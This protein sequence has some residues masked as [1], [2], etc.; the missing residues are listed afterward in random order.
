MVHIVTDPVA[1]SL[2]ESVFSDANTL[3]LTFTYIDAKGRILAITTTNK[4]VSGH[5]L[6]RTFDD[7]SLL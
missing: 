1:N 3:V 4:E 6:I 5:S 2:V 7:T